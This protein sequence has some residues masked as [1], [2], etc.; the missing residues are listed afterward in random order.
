[1][2]NLRPRSIATLAILLAVAVDVAHDGLGHGANR[3]AN[4][5]SGRNARG[6]SACGR[7]HPEPNQLW[8]DSL[9][10]Q[11]C[12]IDRRIRLHF[13]TAD[14]ARPTMMASVIPAA[15]YQTGDCNSGW[16]D[17]MPEAWWWHGC[18]V[19]SG[20]AAAAC[21]LCAQQT[22]CR[23]VQ[24]SGRALLPVLP[25]RAFK[26]CLRQL[27]DADARCRT[28]QARWAHTST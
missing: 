14:A 6:Y 19:W 12:R 1:M 3:S 4:R 20:P 13:S 22:I 26:G 23:L 7:A 24:R 17:C 21:R 9:H 8:A 16:T 11:Q 27:A 2:H 25:Q 10:A 18:S 28:S 5:F 15:D